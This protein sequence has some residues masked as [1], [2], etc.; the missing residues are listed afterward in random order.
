[1][2]LK[3][4]WLLL[5]SDTALYFFVLFFLASKVNFT[6]T[7]QV[8]S[9]TIKCRGDNVSMTNVKTLSSGRN[10]GY[11]LNCPSATVNKFVSMATTGWWPSGRWTGWLTARRKSAYSSATRSTNKNKLGCISITWKWTLFR[12]KSHTKLTNSYTLTSVDIC[13]HHT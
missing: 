2:V 8:L 11:P 10:D 6:A 12:N 3:V 5:F 9:R 4:K 13:T 7:A 1:M